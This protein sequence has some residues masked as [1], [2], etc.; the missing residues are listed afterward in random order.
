MAAPRIVY[1]DSVSP[2]GKPVDAPAFEALMAPLGP[3]EPSP[4]IAVAVSGGPDSLALCLLADRWTRA[5]GGTAIGL[6]VDHGLRPE[7][8]A[9]AAQV[10]GWLASRAIAHR[11]LRWT[12][13][14]AH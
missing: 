5:R 13:R 9:E 14:A 1:L 11:T 8:R 7:S 3:F 4:R 2:A 12:Q 10:R 6:T